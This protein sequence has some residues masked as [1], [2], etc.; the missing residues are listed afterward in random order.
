MDT[1]VGES[2]EQAAFLRSQRS[3]LRF[4]R[5]NS[6]LFHISFVELFLTW[7]QTRAF[8]FMMLPLEIK[9]G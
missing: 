1:L 4:S 6:H 8:M 2:M 7:A 5:Q 3:L 9:E